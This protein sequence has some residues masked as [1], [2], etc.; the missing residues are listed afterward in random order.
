[1]AT[2][3]EL[4]RDKNFLDVKQKL[5]NIDIVEGVLT[6]AGS[7]YLFRNID[8]IMVLYAK[9]PNIKAALSY[10]GWKDFNRHVMRGRSGI[11]TFG[12]ETALG[13]NALF[14][15][16]II[17]TA[18]LDGAEDGFNDLFY[19]K[20]SMSIKEIKS[21]YSDRIND[22]LNKSTIQK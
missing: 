21:L 13:S 16:D 7:L 17:D 10:D 4:E 11:F 15:Y 9:K 22:I 14:F 19:E 3:K 1:M 12:G 6:V 5:K 2:A 20:N 18:V 8:N